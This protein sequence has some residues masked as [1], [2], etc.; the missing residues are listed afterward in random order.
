VIAP[1]I[2]SVA[3]VR[4]L[5]PSQLR[6]CALVAAAAL[7]EARELSSIERVVL[8]SRHLT[9]SVGIAGQITVGVVTVTL[10]YPEPVGAASRPI[11][12]IVGVR[13]LVIVGIRNGQYGR[14]LERP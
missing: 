12:R 8:K 14:N 7:A 10:R 1:A 4:R 13:S 2:E 6:D 11:A 3:P 9:A 5:P